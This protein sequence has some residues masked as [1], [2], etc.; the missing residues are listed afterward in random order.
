M[1][2][3]HNISLGG[4]SFLIEDKAYQELS[5]YLAEVRKSLGN[6]PDTDEI[7]YDVEQRMAELLKT[8]MKG[9][10]VVVSQDV[11]YLIRVL[12]R[13]EQYVDATEETHT[14]DTK[15]PQ[16]EDV[17]RR[18]NTHLKNKKLY[19]DM[20]GKK[21]AGVL[22]GLSYYLNFDVA[23]LRI[24]YLGLLFFT[25]STFVFSKLYHFNVH[26]PL[27]V[28]SGFWLVIYIVFWVLVPQA[29]TNAEK[30]EMQGKSVTID[31]LSASKNKNVTAKKQLYRS[32]KNKMLGGVLG[33]IS[34][35]HNMQTTWVRIIFLIVVLGLIPLVNVSP[36]LVVLY[37]ILWIAI[38]KKP[39]YFDGKDDFSSDS[40]ASDEKTYSE[41]AQTEQN[42]QQ[43]KQQPLFVKQNQNGLWR[44]LRAIIKGILYIIIGFTIFILGI[45]LFSLIMA[46]FGIGIAGWGAGFSFLIINDY[47]P[48]I[49]EGNWQL[50]ITYLSVFSLLVL[51]V[52]VISMLCLKLFSKNGYNTPRVWVLSNVFLFFFGVIGVFIV[53]VDT[54]KHFRTNSFV[55]ETMRFSAKDTISLA[56]K[57]NHYRNS[58]GNNLVDLYGAILKD[59]NEIISRANSVPFFI[60]ET[61]ESEPYI[62]LQKFSRGGNFSQAKQIA[63]QIEYDLKI[64]DSKITLPDLYS[65]GKNSK[66][67]DQKLRIYLY[68]PQGK[69]ITS[70]SEEFSVVNKNKGRVNIGNNT[71]HQMTA[72]GLVKLNGN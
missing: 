24:I 66:I 47:L 33:G 58:Y 65:F 22:S 37:L 55:E 64:E 17:F 72:N 12:G 35:Y 36:L 59:D 48:F 69:Y 23:W 62:V 25:Q 21:L 18:I 26:S 61:E 53:V 8:E 29:K 49:V 46:L 41:E 6:T 56:Y 32:D 42:T 71:V 40:A 5:K 11:A 13:P 67:R 39:F 30:L 14:A 60:K 2:K 63:E 68:F 4:F 50:F 27:V 15:A 51:P 9:R 3:T 1:D 19:R 54:M 34:E 45:V 38:P 7:I 44:F 31:T 28:I 70:S 16:Q 57:S 10:E 52:S 43:T 20:E